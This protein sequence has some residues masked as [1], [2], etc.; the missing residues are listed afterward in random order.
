MSKNGRQ[1]SEE[2]LREALETYREDKKQGRELV[3]AMFRETVER[4][5]QRR[6]E[7]RALV[8]RVHREALE[9]GRFEP[10]PPYERPTIHYTELP[11]AQP[12]SPL[13]LEWS[14]YRREVGRLLAEGQEGR[15]LL[16]KGEEIIGIWDTEEEARAV[17]H[18]RYPMQPYLIQRILTREPL[19]RV[20]PRFWQ[21]QG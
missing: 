6:E 9:Q 8:E 20:S 1:F 11:P 3:E 12:D 17:A 16:I 21:C 2:F 18:T 5:R 15:F 19:L 7:G 4:E 13:C 14:F 10:L